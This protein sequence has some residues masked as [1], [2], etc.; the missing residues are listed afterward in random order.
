[1]ADEGPGIPP[2]DLPRIFDRLYRGDASRSKTPG[3]GLGLALVRAVVEAHGGN[4]SVASESGKGTT[5][6]L[7]FSSPS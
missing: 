2:D 5:F 3:L 4:V 1:V 7:S 6:I